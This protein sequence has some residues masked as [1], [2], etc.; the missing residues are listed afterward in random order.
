LNVLIREVVRPRWAHFRL[1]PPSLDGLTRRRNGG[2]V[3]LLHVDG[4]PVAVAVRGTVFAAR[5][6]DEATARAGIA[7]M[8]FAVGIDDDLE[9]FHER[10]GGDRLIGRAVR[11]R[12]GL[13]VRRQPQPWEALAW[14]ITE[15]LI[16]LERATEI[17]KQLIYRFG[18]R[19]A[20][21]RDSPSAATV[22]ARSPAEIEACGLAPK[23]AIAMRR[24]A[25]EVAAGRVT[26]D[27]DMRRLLAIPEIGTWTVEMLALHGLGRLDV[28]PA[29]DLGYLKI[30]GQITTGNPRAIADEA[31]VRG[32]FARYAP[33]A[34]HA[35]Q[36]VMLSRGKTGLSPLQV[37][38]RSSAAAP[39]T[40]AA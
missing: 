9:E 39:P 23:R 5:A 37:R 31:E 11:M 8:R 27:G 36:Y 32:F 40:V 26:F 6:H 20:G 7:R 35:A 24:A 14:A 17:Q 33:F 4:A 2:L 1:W 16:T 12:P 10:F 13:R 18:P 34:G 22:A 25:R 28:I 30:V 3:R 29:G 38:T 21:L 19:L 15:Q